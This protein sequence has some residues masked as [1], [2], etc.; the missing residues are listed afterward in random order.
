MPTNTL[1]TGSVVR[2]A[3]DVEDKLY[4]FRPDDSPLVSMVERVAINGTFHEWHRDSFATPDATNAAIEGADASNG[5]IAQP[6]PLNN[7][8]QIFTKAWSISN[9]T[10]AVKK[11]GRKTDQSRVKGLR[12]VEMRRDMEAACLSSGAAV[13]GTSG[14]AGKLRGL[15]G[16]IATNDDLGVGGVSPDPT[17]NTAPTAGTLRALTEAQFKSVVLGVYGSGGD[18]KVGL[19]SPAH[20]QKISSAFTGNVTRTHNVDSGDVKPTLVS[21]VDFYRHD[22]G[23]TKMIANRVMSG[24]LPGLQSTLYIID[25]EKIALGQLR[26]IETEELAKTG[27]AR[28]FQMRTEV[29]LIVRDEAP[30]GAIRDLTVSGS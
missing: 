18:A 11:Y 5:A 20:K 13:T 1:L 21:N 26:A 19:C 22:F 12:L 7:R 4:N 30:L 16:F 8:C 15:Y 29:T 27:D 24:A 9:T 2:V 23:V 25:P 3:E 17:T 6:A 28:N 10:E 14:T